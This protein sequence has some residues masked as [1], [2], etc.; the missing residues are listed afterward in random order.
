M[1][2]DVLTLHYKQNHYPRYTVREGGY[3]RLHALMSKKYTENH[4]VMA[5][6]YMGF[7]PD[8]EVIQEVFKLE[9]SSGSIGEGSF[10]ALCKVQVPEVDW[11][12]KTIM[13]VSIY[14][15]LTLRLALYPTSDI[16]CQSNKRI[17][18]AKEQV[19]ASSHLILMFSGFG[20]IRS[21][22]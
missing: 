3:C 9:P 2:I 8:E 14:S 5:I 13:R 22:R 20:P 18:S 4:F 19:H 1:E 6:L 12:P 21:K 16:F 17:R 11:E 7:L 10:Q 15:L